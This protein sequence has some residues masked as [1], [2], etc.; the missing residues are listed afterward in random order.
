MSRLSKDA[1][2]KSSLRQEEVEVPELGGS[3]LIR[4]LPAE[5]AAE[6][7]SH[8]EIKEVAGARFASIDKAKMERLQFAYGV[9]G[10]NG[11]PLFSEDETVE[12][13]KKHGSAYNRVIEAIDD[14]SGINKEDIEN[15]EARFPDS[16]EV[17]A[18]AVEKPAA[19]GANRPHS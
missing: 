11:D 9:V 18:E 7:A 2:D 19:D 8:I 13:A 14:L 5:Y 15:A 4:E 1:W 6:V 10:D 17:E 16:G 3:V 12:V